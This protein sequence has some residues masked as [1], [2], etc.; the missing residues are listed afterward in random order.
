MPSPD[1]RNSIVFLY[2]N[3][4][5]V[6][7]KGRAT[8]TYKSAAYENDPDE[9]YYIPLQM[10]WAVDNPAEWPVRIVPP[11]EINKRLESGHRFRQTA[12][13]ISEDMAKVI[14][15]VWSERSH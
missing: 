15:N 10:S 9:E 1:S 7:A 5:G 6:I 8:S 4:V 11:W 2:H 12:F 13:S 14:D 3:R